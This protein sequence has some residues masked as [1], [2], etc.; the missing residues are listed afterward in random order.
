[1]PKPTDNTQHPEHEQWK[2]EH[3][4]LV[5]RKAEQDA[6]LGRQAFEDFSKN[7]TP[8]SREDREA[9]AR[10]LYDVIEEY[11]AAH[12]E[13][14]KYE[15]L[16]RAEL[17]VGDPPTTKILP[18]LRLKEGEPLREDIYDDSWRYR[19]LI[20]AM[21]PS[22]GQDIGTLAGRVLRDTSFYP[23]PGMKEARLILAALQAAIDRVDEEFHIYEQCLEVARLRERS[24]ACYWERA[25][26]GEFLTYD[27]WH[28]LDKEVQMPDP[29]WGEVAIPIELDRWHRYNNGLWW[30]LEDWRLQDL[31][32]NLIIPESAFW[33]TTSPDE[34]PWGSCVLSDADFFFFPHVY[35]GPAVCQEL[36]PNPEYSLE[37]AAK[38]FGHQHPPVAEWDEATHTYSLRQ[39][40]YRDHD[41][42]IT[43]EWDTGGANDVAGC[44]A[45][46][47][48]IYPDPKQKK[49]VPMIYAV[50]DVF[51]ASLLPLTATRIA[52]FGNRDL[53]RYLG[54][55][56]PSLL[57]RLKNFTGYRSG[58]FL[59]YDAWRETAAR[60][61]WNP[62]FRRH[63]TILDDIRYRLHLEGWIGNN[64][65]SRNR[66][67]D[68]QEE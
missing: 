67:A 43:T 57:Q 60:F 45:Q 35:L 56:A 28:Q 18:R 19:N 7:R 66:P 23:Q 61:H 6:E 36:I 52:E 47:L 62:V 22:S 15:L 33:A 51:G 39:P 24:E 34:A 9:I 30:P 65:A 38:D 10:K 50:G 5:R 2:R 20:K 17:P 21:Q 11:Y 12:R 46:W 1:M 53:W 32:G 25:R 37:R 59:V 27:E 41:D 44:A 42:M 55:D 58:D 31:D 54:N 13:E 63:A 4:E 16:V 64:R 68:E 49:L 26:A 48:V 3:Q 14:R 29:D 40:P 8:L